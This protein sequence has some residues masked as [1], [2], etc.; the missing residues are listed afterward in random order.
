MML[1]GYVFAVVIDIFFLVGRSWERSRWYASLTL[2]RAAHSGKKEAGRAEEGEELSDTSSY[3]AIKYQFI[4]LSH[5]IA[6]NLSSL[7]RDREGS[8]EAVLVVY[9]LDIDI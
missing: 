2:S 4:S 6:Y 8:L 3:R 7:G 5:R 1:V 9:V